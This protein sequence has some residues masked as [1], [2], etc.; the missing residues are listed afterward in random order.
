MVEVGLGG[1]QHMDKNYTQSVVFSEN[2]QLF[3]K[4]AETFN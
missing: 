2:L 3:V 1:K 4:I